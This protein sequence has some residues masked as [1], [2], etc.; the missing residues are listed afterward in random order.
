M[1]LLALS[2]TILRH[3]VAVI[4]VLVLVLL[5]LVYVLKVKPP[6][7]EAN[8]ELALVNPPA[9]PTQ[10]Q[11]QADPKLAKINT[12][13]PYL[14]YGDLTLVGD[15]VVDLVTSHAA[16]QTLA[17]QGVSPKY[18]VSMSSDPGNPAFVDITGVGTTP[19][20]A[21]QAAKDIMV[22]ATGDLQQMQEHVG[23]TPQYM[24]T[25]DALL[26]PTSAQD[27][28][29][30]K[31]RT[32]IEVLGLG[33]IMLFMV[34]SIAEAVSRRREEEYDLDVP[35][36]VKT[37][38]LLSR[39]DRDGREPADHAKEFASPFLSSATRRPVHSL[40]EARSALPPVRAASDVDAL[41]DDD[42]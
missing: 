3:K 21:I 5:G 10:A 33:V 14:A 31:L 29:S 27:Q 13:N 8:G 38:S 35:P 9:A 16:Q 4:P 37:R 6:T 25:S 26:P 11:I 41:S 32:L 23:V 12:N 40:S 24:I 1:D 15:A 42:D 36:A 18:Q 7:Y 20:A 22:Q 19:V 28:I 17:A 2:R 30:S 34:I 39:D